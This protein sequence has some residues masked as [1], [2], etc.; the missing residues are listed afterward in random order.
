M[1]SPS[2]DRMGNPSMGR[3]RFVSDIFGS[4]LFVPWNGFV[5]TI[6]APVGDLSSTHCRVQ[7]APG[8]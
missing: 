7:M 5:L 8:M 2:K 1:R 4:P 3:R 6:R